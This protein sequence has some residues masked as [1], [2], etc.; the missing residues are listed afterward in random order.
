MIL[1]LMEFAGDELDEDQGTETCVNMIDRG[2][3]WHIND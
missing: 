3:L 1:L 2:G